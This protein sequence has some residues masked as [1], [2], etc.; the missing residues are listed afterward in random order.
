MLNIQSLRYGDLARKGLF[1][2]FGLLL[3]GSPTRGQI[4]QN[5]PASLDASPGI[6]IQSFDGKNHR[7]VQHYEALREIVATEF[8]LQP[9]SSCMNL[10]FID[11]ALREALNVD[12]PE[13]FHGEDWCGAFVTPSL[14]FILGEDEADD[15]F[16]HEYLHMLQSR[17]LVFKD[18]PLTAIH[19]AIFDSEGLLL[20][21][22]AV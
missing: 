6:H 21:R 3:A 11:E 2:T 17:G 8:G 13:R 1:L 10:I 16:M 12:N 18:V 15:T 7:S 5:H 22:E 14:I 9:D 20:G 4:N 19:H